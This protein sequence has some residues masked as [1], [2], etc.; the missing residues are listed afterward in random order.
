MY[1]EVQQATESHEI[2]R[3]MTLYDEATT[4]M[5]RSSIDDWNRRADAWEDA[6]RG[7]TATAEESLIR[8]S[9]TIAFLQVHGALQRDMDVADLGCGP[10]RF[11]AHFA[12]H[13]RQVTGFDLSPRMLQYAARYATE[14]GCTNVDFRIADFRIFDAAEEDLNEKYDLVFASISPAA[15]GVAGITRMMQLSRRFCF[16]SQFVDADDRLLN[17]I[18]LALFNEKP[19]PR[20]NALGVYALFNLLFIAGYAPVIRYFESHKET[21]CPADRDNAER[22]AGLLQGID[23]A[24]VSVDRILDWL[25]KN[26][27]NDKTLAEASVYR[28]AWILWDI[29]ARCERVVFPD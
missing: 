22:I 29:T 23:G 16:V 20:W 24:T 3:L 15:N 11:A 12:A 7:S 2:T 21:R 4:R 19:R 26:A 14:C 27:D 25:L 10:G 28:Y 17:R 1:F 13:C 9:E 8:V 18:G 5:G 6:F